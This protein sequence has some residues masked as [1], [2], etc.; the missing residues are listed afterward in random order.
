MYDEKSDEEESSSN[1]YTGISDNIC[2]VIS[3]LWN[4]REKHINT[5][6]AMTGWML[7]VIPHII[8]DVFKY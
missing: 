4:K 6:Y 7:C 2:L 5:D 3:K 1:G 8:K